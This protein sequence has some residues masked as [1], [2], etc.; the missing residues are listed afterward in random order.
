MTDDLLKKIAKIELIVM[1]VDGV[2]TPGDVMYPG[3]TG[4][5]KTFNTKDG[6]GMKYWIRAGGRMAWITGRGG[7]P[8]ERRAK[9]LGVDE[10]RQDVKAKRPVLD[11]VLETMGIAPKNVCVIGDD[12]TD[13]PMMYPCAMSACPGDAVAEVKDYV[14]YVCTLPGGRGCVRELVE[15]ILKNSGR[16]DQI[17]ARYL[18][19]E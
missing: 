8:V 18:P 1:D 14:D 5:I 12:L 11:E 13:L 17:M 15:V 16:W 6:A 9:E 2:M 10:L 4:E 19:E 7:E 3:A